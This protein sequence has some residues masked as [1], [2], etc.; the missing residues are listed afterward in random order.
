MSD[1]LPDCMLC[2]YS[3][4]SVGGYIVIDYNRTDYS[5]YEI[6][7][8]VFFPDGWYGYE[9]EKGKIMVNTDTGDYEINPGTVWYD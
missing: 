6:T 2:G 9:T 8:S 1:E 4:E 5:K 7:T 3:L